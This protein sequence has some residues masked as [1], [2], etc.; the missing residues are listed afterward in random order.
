MQL[1]S[2]MNVLHTVSSSER[3]ELSNGS[4]I[5]AIFTNFPTFAGLLSSEPSLMSGGGTGGR[6]APLYL[7]N[8]YSWPVGGV[9]K[10]KNIA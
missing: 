7:G 1:F 9:K 4:S 5:A 2:G 6:A 3:T 8:I 10:N